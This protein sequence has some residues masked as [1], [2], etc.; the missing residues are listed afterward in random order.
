MMQD[1]PT[2]QN[3]ARPLRR[4]RIAVVEK[5]GRTKTIK[6]RI[7]RLVKHAKYGKYLKRR[8]YLHVH[9]EKNE[10]RTGDVVEIMECRPMSKT[11]AW[12]LVNVVKRAGRETAAV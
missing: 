12:R 8:S 4:T 11:K 9:D 2:T 7:D 1:A 5:H 10:A 3:D 6:V